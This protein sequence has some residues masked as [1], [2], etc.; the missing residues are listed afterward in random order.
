MFACR[1]ACAAV[2]EI[3]FNNGKPLT[4]IELHRAAYEKIKTFV[5]SGQIACSV[6]RRVAASY[7]SAKSNK[8]PA[9]KPFAFVRLWALWLIGVR[10]RDARICDDGT[11]SIWTVNGRKRIA[12]TIPD[13]LRADFD[14]GLETVET[15]GSAMG[16]TP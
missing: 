2:S 12:F 10:G 4:N 14:A 8:R 13:R 6:S 7:K 5:P 9:T 16:Y 15:A 3:A 1:D 11:L